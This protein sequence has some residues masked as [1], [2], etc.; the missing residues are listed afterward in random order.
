M[1][2]SFSRFHTAVLLLAISLLA[3]SNAAVAA[4]AHSKELKR[5]LQ[6][7]YTVT[8]TSID[9]LRVTHPGSVLVIEQNGIAGNPST[10]AFPTKT[11]VENGQIRQAR[12]VF[13]AL[14]AS[15]D[16][17]IFQQGEHVYITHIYLGPN[18]VM[19][20]LSSVETHD[21]DIHG[22]T[23]QVRYNATINFRFPDDK[24]QSMTA[25]DLKSAIDPFLRLQE[26]ADQPQTIEIG[27]SIQDIER[28]MGK[29]ERI[30]KAGS[31]TIYVYPDLKIT[32]VDD[33]VSDVE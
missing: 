23:K 26:E 5:S 2:A 17:R 7:I 1:K 4:N 21:V 13:A 14:N 28:I 6:T 33:K 27:Q 10:K 24:Y 30:V 12:G 29:P 11:I 25:E 16:T 3:A 18:N 31:K 8:K 19:F 9:Q 15:Q 32:F 20:D 22:T